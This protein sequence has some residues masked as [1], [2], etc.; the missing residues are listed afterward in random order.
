MLLIVANQFF[1]S[2]VGRLL[3]SH[4]VED[5]RSDIGQ[6]TI[7]YGSRIVVGNVNKWYWVK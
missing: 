4:N 3:Q 1:A 5:R 2:H 6:T 7:L